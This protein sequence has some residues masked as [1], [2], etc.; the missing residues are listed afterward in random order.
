MYCS[1]TVAPSIPNRGNVNARDLFPQALSAQI[2]GISEQFRTAEGSPSRVASN[3][4]WMSPFP[5]FSVSN[6]GSGT[7][8]VVNPSRSWTGI[9]HCGLSYYTHWS[10]AEN[11]LFLLWIFDLIAKACFFASVPISDGKRSRRV[12]SSAVLSRHLAGFLLRSH[13]GSLRSAFVFSFST[14]AYGSLPLPPFVVPA[15]WPVGGGSLIFK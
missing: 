5:L 14:F 4:W 2:F 12:M 3:S 15:R 6:T 10:V 11:R 9:G 8:A 7:D 1:I 13:F